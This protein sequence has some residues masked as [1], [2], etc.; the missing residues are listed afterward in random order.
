MPFPL[1]LQ[2]LSVYCVYCRSLEVYSQQTSVFSETTI[3]TLEK[4]V[5]YIH[6]FY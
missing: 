2:A 5:K 1:G 3:E 4:G 6:F